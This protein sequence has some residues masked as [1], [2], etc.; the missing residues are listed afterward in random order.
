M[1]KVSME[2]FGERLMASGLVLS[3]EIKWIAFHG[4]YSSFH[5]QTYD[6]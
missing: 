2:A 3:D 4:M 6:S 5:N 1:L